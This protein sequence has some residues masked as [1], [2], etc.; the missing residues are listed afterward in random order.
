MPDI[1]QRMAF[2]FATRAQI[3]R[4]VAVGLARGAPDIDP[5]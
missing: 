5:L 4:L 1:V 2:V 3:E